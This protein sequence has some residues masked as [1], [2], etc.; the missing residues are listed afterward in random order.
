MTVLRGDKN[1]A[2]TYQGTLKRFGE[3]ALALAED[4]KTGI[5]TSDGNSVEAIFGRIRELINQGGLT[6]D[7]IDTLRDLV[8][9]S[10]L[11]VLQNLAEHTA[12]KT[13]PILY[14]PTTDDWDI[15]ATTET[16]EKYGRFLIVDSRLENPI[17]YNAMQP[18]LQQF[19]VEISPAIII[20][21]FPDDMPRQN[22]RLEWYRS[23]T[24]RSI[25]PLDQFHLA[26]TQEVV[27]QNIPAGY[28]AYWYG[29]EAHFFALY[30]TVP[31]DN[32][33]LQALDHQI[34]W[35]GLFGPEAI[36]AIEEVIGNNRQ[37]GH[38]ESRLLSNYDFRAAQELV[39]NLTRQVEH[40][41]GQ[42]LSEERGR[43]L[44]AEP[45]VG[46]AEDSDYLYWI[47]ASSQDHAIQRMHKQT[48]KINA[49]S[50]QLSAD[51]YGLAI[52]EDGD[53]WTTVRVNNGGQ[54]TFEIRC[55]QAD[56]TRQASKEPA[57]TEPVHRHSDRADG[58]CIAVSPTYLLIAEVNGD[59]SCW[60]ERGNTDGDNNILPLWSQNNEGTADIS[61]YDGAFYVLRSDGSLLK[62]FSDDGEF[63][64][65][66]ANDIDLSARG[67]S[68]PLGLAVG[69]RRAYISTANHL[70]A[71]SYFNGYE[72]VLANIG[73]QQI[74][75]T[76]STSERQ[77]MMGGG[78]S[79]N[80]IPDG[81]ADTQHAH[82]I[83]RLHLDGYY[84]RT[85]FYGE[86]VLHKH[87][88]GVAWPDHYY[89]RVDDN[90]NLVPTTDGSD[91]AE[92]NLN[93]YAGT[94]RNMFYSNT[95][96]HAL[97]S[98]SSKSHTLT[99]PNNNFGET[100]FQANRDDNFVFVI[101]HPNF[102]FDPE[103]FTTFLDVI[104]NEGAD[105]DFL[106]G[107]TRI[108]CSRDGNGDRYAMKLQDGVSTAPDN[109]KV[110]NIFNR[111]SR[112]YNLDS[113]NLPNRVNVNGET[114]FIIPYI[115][116]GKIH[117]VIALDVPITLK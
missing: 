32:F 70:Y 8:S 69:L 2:Q 61:Y 79:Y 86:V 77:L 44:T 16:G 25:F 84:N 15:V 47:G 21:V 72:A 58:Y 30:K 82:D 116:N 93:A 6:F 43:T 108:I 37:P 10:V 101:N 65:D 112:T 28:S 115:P 98:D 114:T 75:L 76:T 11:E 19:D 73:N 20:G 50:L 41:K 107:R 89:Y 80:I 62:K 90:G 3:N 13:A 40:E 87:V 81:Q 68:D 106:A 9:S 22:F 49:L 5:M 74:K 83:V 102:S 7:E 55:F 66:A 39:A 42:D 57:S 63:D 48:L 14:S 92:S 95:H 34:R 113:G 88:S 105:R 91:T 104:A 71:F 67:Y 26:P 100:V 60:W 46:L 31:N 94:G 18:R 53:F 54:N 103:S 64:T 33:T 78:A 24:Q 38:S 51:Y 29:S 27:I 12:L 4:I 45:N 35:D 1:S 99:I 23:S 109:F 52:D 96:R 56:G 36:K 111:T 117:A 110:H 17:N 85:R 97:I 59:S